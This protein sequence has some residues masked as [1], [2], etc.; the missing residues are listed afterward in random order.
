MLTAN[1]ED[2]PR[3]PSSKHSLWS[4][5]CH[6]SVRRTIPPQIEKCEDNA[7]AI[8]AEIACGCLGPVATGG[9]AWLTLLRRKVAFTDATLP[10]I[11]F[12]RVAMITILKCGPERH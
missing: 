4:L 7:H 8:C 12:R 2:G 3:G 5:L 11:R 10:I 9:R 6:S 1:I